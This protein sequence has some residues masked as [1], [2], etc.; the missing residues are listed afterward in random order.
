MKSRLSPLKQTLALAAA[1]MVA[2][3]GL[4]LSTPERASAQDAARI[5]AQTRPNFGVLLD[6]PTQTRRRAP[7]PRW[8]YGAHRPG[9]RPPPPMRGGEEIVLVE[10]GGDAPTGAVEEALRRVRPGGTLMLR[11]RGGPCIGWL[12][13]DKPVIIMG[14]DRFDA[15]DWRRGAPPTLQAPDGYPCLTAMPG[16]RVEVRDVVFAAPNGG[17]AACIEG[18]GAELVLK[19]VGIRYAGDDSAIYASDGLID[20]RESR[21]E[22]QTLGAA[23]VADGAAITSDDL[24]IEGAR[25]GV[26][27]VPGAQRTTILHRTRL[28]G[29]A[30]RGRQGARSVGVLIGG[31]RAFGQLELDHVTV[32][33]YDDGVSIEGAGV[34]ITRSRLCLLDKG[35]V[36][37]SGSID[38]TDSRI[39]RTDV[40]VLVGLGSGRVTGNVFS[41]VERT[42][43]GPRDVIS[44]GNRLW[45]RDDRCKPQFVRVYRDRYAPE[46]RDHPGGFRCEIAPYPREWWSQDEGALGVP[47]ED[48]AYRLDRFDDFSSGWGWYDCRDRYVPD[49]R[50]RDGD[51]WTRGGWGNNRECRDRSGGPTGLYI[52]GDFHIDVGAGLGIDW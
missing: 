1:A 40:G 20:I 5:E 16:V 24:I 23:I 51:R 12:N 29:T 17:R 22:A 25:N 39:S 45:A 14:A 49:R 21:I 44:S 33:G 27:I 36:V 30:S 28:I 9:H 42:V 35:V 18:Q 31:S 50:W 47:Y 3:T 48:F 26:E 41:G 19:N 4:V 43:D 52:F 46:W 37:Y 8:D 10:C 13:V 34:S 32:C 2:A 15:R 7:R 11:S 38:L 6:P